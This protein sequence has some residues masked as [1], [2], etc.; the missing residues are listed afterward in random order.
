MLNTHY[1]LML[2][3]L[4]QKNDNFVFIKMFKNSFL[5]FEEQS[6]PIKNKSLFNNSW[7]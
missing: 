1:D 7:G 4:Q 2:T 3:F 6:F 5:C